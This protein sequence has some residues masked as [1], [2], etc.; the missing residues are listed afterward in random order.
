[1]KLTLIDIFLKLIPESFILIWG[2]SAIS[3]KLIS[4]KIHI[5]YC[6]LLSIEVYVVRLLPIHF[7]VHTIISNI[8]IICLLII[9]EFSID[10][11]IRN[12]LLMTLLLVISEFLNILL[13]KIFNI[14]IEVHFKIPGV[15]SFLFL[16]SLLFLILLIY[17]TKFLLRKKVEKINVTD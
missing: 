13:L 11:A 15:E 1:M 16:P 14:N 5:I 2:I 10:T 17:L 3:N 8:F 4:K 6:I 9:A 12:T 7:G